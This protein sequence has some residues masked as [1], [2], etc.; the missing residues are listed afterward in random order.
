MIGLI[1]ALL[2]W[3]LVA[4]TAL[5]TGIACVAAW[6]RERLWKAWKHWKERKDN[7]SFTG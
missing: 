5:V 2:F 3:P 1:A 4:A 6:V 7:G